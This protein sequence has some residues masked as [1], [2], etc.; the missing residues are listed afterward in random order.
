MSYSAT[1]CVPVSFSIGDV[2]SCSGDWSS[3]GSSTKHAGGGVCSFK[4]VC[5]SSVGGQEMEC[6]H[7][8]CRSS[9]RGYLQPQD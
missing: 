9:G 4:R 6:W 1:S 2:H 8:L 3:E 7:D 5:A